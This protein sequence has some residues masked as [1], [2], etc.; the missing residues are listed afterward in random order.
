M[1]KRLLTIY[2]LYWNIIVTY[3]SVVSLHKFP[4]L[5]MP[6]WWCPSRRMYNNNNNNKVFD[7]CLKS[8]AETYVNLKP[9]SH[10]TSLVDFSELLWQSLKWFMKWKTFSIFNFFGTGINWK[11]LKHCSFLTASTIKRS[12]PKPSQAMI[13]ILDQI[14]Y[15][16]PHCYCQCPLSWSLSP[17]FN[18]RI[19]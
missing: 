19:Q 5:E 1:N 11:E 12:Q 3:M 2:I 7:L 17:R 9:L 10:P 14:F 8:L 15:F 13:W 6:D 4:V 18:K 16:V